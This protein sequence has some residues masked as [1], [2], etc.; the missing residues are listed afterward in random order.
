MLFQGSML[1]ASINGRPDVE[2]SLLGIVGIGATT[3]LAR[4]QLLAGDGRL[5]AMRFRILNSNAE[6]VVRNFAQGPPKA[7]AS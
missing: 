6:R 5:V 4:G 2:V 7:Y 1:R 3:V